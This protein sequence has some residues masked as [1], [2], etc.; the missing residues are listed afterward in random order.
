MVCDA[1]YSLSTL[2][3]TD[4]KFYPAPSTTSPPAGKSVFYRPTTPPPAPHTT[5]RPST[6]SSNHS[7][8]PTTLV[9]NLSLSYFSGT[10]THTSELSKRL[11]LLVPT[12]HLD[13]VTLIRLINRHHNRPLS[14]LAVTD[15]FLICSPLP[16]S[17][18]STVVFHSPAP[19]AQRELM[20]CRTR[21]DPG[22]GGGGGV[23][24]RGED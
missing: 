5:S 23:Y 22:C 3:R 12:H 19:P 21:V 20:L 13:Q 16:P 15:T 18:S 10:S 9:Q 17:S 11:Y 1:I 14:P 6:T 24:G 7:S 2:Y 8:P 4:T